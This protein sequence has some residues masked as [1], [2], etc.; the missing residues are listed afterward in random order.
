MHDATIV[1]RVQRMFSRLGPELDER[2]RRVW[3]A[4][5]AM[6]LGWGG[7]SAVAKATGLSRTTIR[8]GIADLQQPPQ[9]LSRVRR[10]GGGRKSLTAHD[11]QLPSAL[12]SLVEP[13][14]R[15]EPDSPLRWTIR[16]ARVLAE[17][18]TRQGHPVSHSTVA[19]LLQEAGF[20]LQ[21][22]RKTR[23]GGTHPDRNA[24]FL[25]LNEQVK[26]C[27]RHRQPAVSVDTKKKELVGD[28]KNGG[29]EYRRRGQA[30]KVRVHDFK[31]PELGKAIP[32]GVYDLQHNE[33]WVSVGIDHDTAEFAANTIRRWWKRMGRKRFP[34][35]KELLITAD[36]G[37]SNSSRSRLWK[38]ALQNFADAT[39]MKLTVCHFPPGTSKWNK[40]EHRLFSFITM[41]WRGKP[42]VSVEAIVELIG[43][44]TT[45]EGLQVQTAIDPKQ[46]QAGI[47]VSDQQLAQV[48]FQPHAFHGDWNYSIVPH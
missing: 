22:N 4:A 40:I 42:L 27:Q 13:T 25:Y 38:V 9:D 21:A 18:L 28:F 37:G 19:S 20:S 11:P 44:T 6:E 46:Y 16:S 32:Y 30:Q 23:E 8:A 10:P 33:G 5:E 3:A 36:S 39:G 17:T 41:N 29:R 47:K 24:Q 45:R 34:Q 31:D 2:S 7:A 26:R 48:R 1:E 35:A 15:G 14:E 12:E 43:N